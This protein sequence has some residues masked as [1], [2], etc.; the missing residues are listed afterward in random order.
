MTA[1]VSPDVSTD[2]ARH[3]ARAA[4]QVASHYHSEEDNTPKTP[5][6]ETIVKST[7]TGNAARDYE[8]LVA[9]VFEAILKQDQVHTL[10]IRHDA[11]VRGLSG[12]EFQIDVYWRFK[13]VGLEY[14]AIV[15]V[16]NWKKRIKR[17]VVQMLESTLRDV[18]GQPRGVIVSARGFQ[19]GAIA[20]AKAHGIELY[21]LAEDFNEPIVMSTLG[22][23]RVSLA[24]ELKAGRLYGRLVM[25]NPKV[26][27]RAK[28]VGGGL[29]DMERQKLQSKKTDLSM[30]RFI[31]DERGIAIETISSIVRRHLKPATKESKVVFT[32]Q[33]EK[34]TFFDP[35]GDGMS[36][37]LESL[38]FDVE[39]VTKT[40]D[41]IF[42]SESV[43]DLILTNIVTG[44]IKRFSR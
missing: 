41:R 44:D 35:W 38:T 2:G 43:V 39:I 11:K 7:G 19:S 21:T 25:F 28:F 8:R 3:R 27:I 24:P 26:S 14:S 36:L 5:A 31:Y 29:S 33:F 13:A 30:E 34:P 32:E 40:I 6:K 4:R 37:P 10:E 20:F 16:K 12:E 22:W 1:L 15:E 42:R 9:S 23:A 18:P 17:N